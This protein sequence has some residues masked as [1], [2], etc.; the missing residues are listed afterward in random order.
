MVLEN[1]LAGLGEAGW[2]SNKTI[3][4]FGYLSQTFYNVGIIRMGRVLKLALDEA[5]HSRLEQ[6][7]QHSISQLLAVEGAAV[8]SLIE[9]GEEALRLLDTVAAL[10]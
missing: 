2:E 10:L 1:Y 8:Y 5:Q 6:Q 9:R 4:R 7:Q 3:V